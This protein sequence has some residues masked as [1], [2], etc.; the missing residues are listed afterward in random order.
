MSLSW[1]P[2]VSSSLFARFMIW[3]AAL[4]MITV[5][6]IIFFFQRQ[7]VRTIDERSRREGYLLAQNIANLNLNALI[8]WDRET[9]R[10]NLSSLHDPNILYV[11]FF[12][13]YSNLFVATDSVED[14]EEIIC[15]SYLPEQ[16]E[17]NTVVYRPALFEV[18]G[19]KMKIREIEIPIFAPGSPIRWGSVKIGLSLEAM[20]SEIK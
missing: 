18:N 3:V 6:M 14:K 11:V 8:W 17:E 20:R 15:C 16:I 2:K 1:L 4:L 7:E 13:R 5:G 19:K 12:D 10:R 9:V